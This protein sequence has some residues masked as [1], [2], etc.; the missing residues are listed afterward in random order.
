MELDAA[1]GKI[2]R[3]KSETAWGRIEGERSGIVLVDKHV[4]LV[5]KARVEEP[6]RSERRQ[7]KALPGLVQTVIASDHHC[8]VA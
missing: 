5:A 1:F 4:A 2:R 7:A 8:S 6:V 3:P